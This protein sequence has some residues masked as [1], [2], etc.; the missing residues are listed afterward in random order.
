MRIFLLGLAVYTPMVLGLAI[1]AEEPIPA[2][3]FNRMAKALDGRRV[4]GDLILM[5]G[6]RTRS[7][8]S[9]RS[10]YRQRVRSGQESLG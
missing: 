6:E 1:A 3:L 8:I 7:S 2:D 4:K 10:L 9:L 5:G